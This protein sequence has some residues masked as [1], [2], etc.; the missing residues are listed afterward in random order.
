MNIFGIQMYIHTRL[1]D[2]QNKIS[3]RIALLQTVSLNN[4]VNL[5]SNENHPNISNHP[6]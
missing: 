1:D 6:I 3:R 5:F 4:Y 2:A